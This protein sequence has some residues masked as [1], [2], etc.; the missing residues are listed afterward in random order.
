MNK[1]DITIVLPVRNEEKYIDGCIES[2]VNQTYPL[3]HIRLVICDGMSEDNTIKH[4]LKYQTLYNNFITVIK[5]TQKIVPTALN[6]CIRKLDTDYLIRIDAHSDYPVDYIEKCIETIQTVDADNVG[7]LTCTKGKGLIGEA[8]AQVISSKFGVGN[9]SF[10]TG[11]KSGYVDTV[12]FG[13]F[14]KSTFSK[15]GEFNEQLVR[16]Q[17]NEFNFRI[18]KNG[19]KVYLNSNIVLNYYCRDS[20]KEIIKQGVENGKWNVIAMKMCPGSMGIRHFVPCVFLISIVILTV[21]GVFLVWPRW[22]LVIELFLYLILDA[23]FSMKI[24]NK[25]YDNHYL[26]KFILYPLFHLSYGLGSLL[27]ILKIFSR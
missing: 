8:F 15:Y 25:T 16:N 24:T 27:G 14:K 23:F 4:I 7:G 18:R 12:P 20:I 21:L 9:S 1:P 26:T 13:T 19:G 6:L 10:R 3:K 2:I 5:N 17:D 22:L 11:A